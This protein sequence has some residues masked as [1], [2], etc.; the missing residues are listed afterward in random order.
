MIAVV[1]G[2]ERPPFE[3]REGLRAR[4]RESSPEKRERVGVRIA[5]RSV[6]APRDGSAASS[7]VRGTPRGGERRGEKRRERA[8]VHEREIERRARRA[9]RHRDEFF[10]HSG[11]RRARVDVHQDVRDA[12]REKR[13]FGDVRDVK[14]RRVC[15]RSA[16]RIGVVRIAKGEDAEGTVGEGHERRPAQIRRAR[17][18]VGIDVRDAIRQKRERAL[19]RIQRRVRAGFAQERANRRGG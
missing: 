13:K 3:R 18:V 15:V 2:E 14:R 16:M 17:R 9:R 12:A 4:R 8:R 1:H 5:V 19:A 10:R 7:A 6:R 11:N